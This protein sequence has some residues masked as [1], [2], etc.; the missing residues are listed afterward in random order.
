MTPKTIANYGGPYADSE[1]KVN[2]ETDLD[3]T[4]GNRLLEDLAQ[5]TRTKPKAMVRFTATATAAPTTVEPTFWDTIW[6][7]GLAQKPTIDKIATGEYVVSFATSYVDALGVSETVTF[8]YAAIV[9]RTSVK[10]EDI[11]YWD[12]RNAF[13]SNTWYVGLKEA[14]TLDDVTAGAN[15]IECTLILF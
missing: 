15:A 5:L 7:S 11:R 10:T 4:N 12:G 6:G 1:G 13:G 3:A 8:T 14:N 2:P 9:A